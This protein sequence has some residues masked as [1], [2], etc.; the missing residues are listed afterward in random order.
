M[1]QDQGAGAIESGVVM[2]AG[3][4]SVRR[5]NVPPGLA[6]RL[7][8]GELGEEEPGV[9][10]EEPPS[11]AAR[12]A[13]GPAPVA[14]SCSVRVVGEEAPLERRHRVVGQSREVGHQLAQRRAGKGDVDPLRDRV[15]E[16]ELAELGRLD[17]RRSG[18]LLVERGDGEDRFGGDR[19][20]GLD[21][22]Q[23]V[24]RHPRRPRRRAPPRAPAR[25]SCAAP[26]R[27]P[28]S[29]RWRRPR[30]RR[31]A[32]ARARRAAAIFGRIG[33][34]FCSKPAAGCEAIL[35]R[36]GPAGENRATICAIDSRW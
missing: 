33:S 22:G 24:A 26:S 1:R 11:R 34:S 8:G 14:S 30:R 6:D 36:C 7:L 35:A 23:P 25:E 12:S 27:A 19:R 4:N 15:V 29:R 9:G 2:P 10:V 16:P 5:M 31:A 28:D 17:Q 20:R 18:H 3:T 21:V 13:P 32:R